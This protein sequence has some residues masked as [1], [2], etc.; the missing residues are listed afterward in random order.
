MFVNFRMSHHLSDGG[1]AS[2]DRHCIGKTGKTGQFAR[3]RRGKS[4]QFARTSRALLWRALP[5]ALA[6]ITAGVPS[7][8]AGAETLPPNFEEQIV[9][10]GLT[11]PTAVRFASDGRVFVAEKSGLIKVFDDLSDATATVVADLRTQVHNFWDRGLLGLAVDPGFPARPYLYALYAHDAEIGGGAPRW[12]TLGETDDACPDPSV[13]GCVVSGRLSRLQLGADGVMV[14]SEQVLIEDWCQQFSHSVG[15]L[16]FGDDGALYVSAGDGAS[17]ALLDYGQLGDPPNPCLDPPGGVAEIAPP[18]AE[19]GSLRS[20]DLR[21]SGDPVNLN[22]AVLRLDPR[23]GAGMPNNPYAD[24]PDFNARRIIAYG[25]R[26]PYRMTTRPGTNEL[27]VTDPGWH[28]WEEI[29]VVADVADSVGENFGWPCYEGGQPQASWDAAD[30]AIC[31]NLYAEPGAVTHPYFAYPSSEKVVPGEG[32]PTDFTAPSGITFRFY[33]AGSYPADY[34]GALFFADYSR[35]CIWVMPKGGDGRPDAKAR[36][37]F[38]EGAANPVD[39]QI[40]P[41]GDVFYVDFDGG[42][43]RRIVYTGRGI[44]ATVGGLRVRLGLDLLPEASKDRSAD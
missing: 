33:D 10:S 7:L 19:G 42:T 37:T 18:A 21:T 2:S 43:I 30:L 36:R 31:E 27:W 44:E 41:A 3:N 17:S 13:T 1:P 4:E 34:D 16:M 24:S 14:G 28:D 39:L 9:F 26:N 8:P 32:C 15:D 6:L 11:N 35:D 29:N 23:T 22:G 5:I 20:Q 38:V 25:L 40:G 12:G